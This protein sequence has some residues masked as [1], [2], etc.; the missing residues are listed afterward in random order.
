MKALRGNAVD[1]TDS[2]MW[3]T[4][5]IANL[6]VFYVPSYVQKRAL[7]KTVVRQRR[8]H[9]TE[10]Q[11]YPRLSYASPGLLQLHSATGGLHVSLERPH[12]NDVLID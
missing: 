7:N 4:A 6:S 3:P 10:P 2:T 1:E 11:L 9:A 12:T 5:C 8:R